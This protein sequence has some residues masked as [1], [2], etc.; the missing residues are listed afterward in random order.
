VEGERAPLLLNLASVAESAGDYPRALQLFDEGIAL[1]ERSEP[2]MDSLRLRQAKRSRA[3]ALGLMGRGDEAREILRSLERRALALDGE[4]AFEPAMLAWQQAVLARHLGEV[5]V[6]L[7]ALTVAEA[8]MRPLLPPE[9]AIHAYMARVRG[10]LLGVQGDLDGAARA[11]D[12]GIAHLQRSGGV[13]FDIASLQVERARVH[14]LRG[15]LSQARAL[16]REALPVL[17][18]AVLPTE[19]TRAMAERL[20]RELGVQPARSTRAEGAPRST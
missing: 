6:G 3:R 9:H 15:E 1:L 13:A 4:D 14:Q 17:R 16:L 18:Q 20:A 8:R 12:A 11:L 2:D 5:E 10:H 7:A 19:V